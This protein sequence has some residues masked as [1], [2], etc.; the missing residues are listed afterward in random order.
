MWQALEPDNEAVRRD[1]AGNIGVD[2]EELA[3]TRNASESLQ[4]A[5]LGLDLAPG[6]EVLTTDQDYGR[7]L[8]TW[9]QRV[10]ATASS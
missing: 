7:M 6:D 1:L 2:P 9:E 10:A 3:L 4:I 5:Q 8:D